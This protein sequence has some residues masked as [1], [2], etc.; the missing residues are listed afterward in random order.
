MSAEQERS[1]SLREHTEMM[2]RWGE[3]PQDP[4]A[5]ERSEE[6]AAQAALPSE[7]DRRDRWAGGQDEADAA[8]SPSG[9]Q[10]SGSR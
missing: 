1:E 3:N 8:D 6:L 5:H 10:A 4:R 9:D 7:A 2:E